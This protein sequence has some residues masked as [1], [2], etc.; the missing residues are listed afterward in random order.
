[1]K[2]AAAQTKIIK[3]NIGVSDDRGLPGSDKLRFLGFI[4]SHP[5]Q[6]ELT[7]SVGDEL[8]HRRLAEKLGDY[9]GILINPEHELIG[10][11]Y[12]GKEIKQARLKLVGKKC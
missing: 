12:G 11:Y 7:Y 4:H 10:A 1:M 5:I 3:R 9:I 2:H 8:I 6:E